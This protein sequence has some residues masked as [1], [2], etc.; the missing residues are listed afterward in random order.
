MRPRPA[1]GHCAWSKIRYVVV[2]KR[3]CRSLRR[4]SKVVSRSE[5]RSRPPSFLVRPLPHAGE[6]SQEE[7]LTFCTAHRCLLVV[8]P[9]CSRS[10][11]TRGSRELMRVDEGHC[12]CS[13]RRRSVVTRLTERSTNREKHRLPSHRSLN[14]HTPIPTPSS[15]TSPPCSDCPT[16]SVSCEP[17][18]S[19]SK[20][21]YHCGSSPTSAACPLSGSFPLPSTQHLSF[22]VLRLPKPAGGGLPKAGDLSLGVRRGRCSL[23]SSLAR[24]AHDELKPQEEGQWENDACG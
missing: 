12:E 22:L 21:P 14:L 10:T 24:F 15:P 4:N 2:L 5:V 13:R 9:G 17:T 8:S 3:K 1:S 20:P 19:V 6:C 16:S 7:A 18:S 11:G 23:S